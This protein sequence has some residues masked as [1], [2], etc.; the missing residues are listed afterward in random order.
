MSS[1]SGPYRCTRVKDLGEQTYRATFETLGES[2]SLPDRVELMTSD[3]Q[4]FTPG[5]E[6]AIDFALT[7][8]SWSASDGSAR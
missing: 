5:M 7:P 1:I 6:V 2:L 3:A 8:T 4:R